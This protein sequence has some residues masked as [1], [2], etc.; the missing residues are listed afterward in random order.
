MVCTRMLGAYCIAGIEE[1]NFSWIRP[2]RKAGKPL[3]YVDIK[4]V[5]GNRM[6]MYDLIELDFDKR[7]N[8]KPHSE[9][10]KIKSGEYPLLIKKIPI[11][12]NI[13]KLCS[14]KDESKKISPNIKDFLVG[15]NRSL[16]LIK[17]DEIKGLGLLDPFDGKYKPT[18]N[19]TLND[20]YYSYSC[21]DLKWRK[22]GRLKGGKN[23]MKNLL[24][25]EEL[26]FSIG[27]SRLF[28]EDY[29]PFIIG[30]HIFPDYDATV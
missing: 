5:N 6:E 3:Q 15:N 1:K 29:W 9:D 17:P 23:K 19:F 2:I 28:R 24:E 21:T 8:N 12:D 16:I 20:V 7:L 11:S 27:L 22:L 18:I 30:V 4:C 10:F 26:Y 14:K 25:S 13:K